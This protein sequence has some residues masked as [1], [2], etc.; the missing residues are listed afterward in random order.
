MLSDVHMRAFLL[1]FQ[2]PVMTDLQKECTLV[3]QQF[4][5][6]IKNVESIYSPDS[7]HEQDPRNQEDDQK[8]MDPDDKQ[9]ADDYGFSIYG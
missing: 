8:P 7:Q 4:A 1:P 3:H 6:Y 2:G 9:I 5:K